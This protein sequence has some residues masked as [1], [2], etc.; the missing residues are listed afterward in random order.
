MPRDGAR[1]PGQDQEGS[2]KGVLCI[3]LVPEHAPADAPDEGTMPPD[4]RDKSVLVTLRREAFEQLLVRHIASV[5]TTQPVVQV[6]E[7]GPQLLVG[8]DAPE[9]P[10]MSTTILM[11]GSGNSAPTFLP[12]LIAGEAPSTTRLLQPTGRNPLDHRLR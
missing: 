5:R 3:L 7:E 4:E 6:P 1:L 12:V 9:W 11:G 10:A 2:L 8:H